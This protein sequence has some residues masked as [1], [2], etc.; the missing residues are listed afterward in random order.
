MKKVRNVSDIFDSWKERGLFLPSMQLLLSGAD[1]SYK[2][3][4]HM[5]GNS[6]ILET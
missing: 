3:Q 1:E 4:A 6:F 5:L 2:D